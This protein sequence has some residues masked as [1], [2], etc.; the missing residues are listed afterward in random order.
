[1]WEFPTVATVPRTRNTTGRLREGNGM[2]TGEQRVSLAYR[3][4]EG[5][6]NLEREQGG[7]RD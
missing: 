6:E 2:A 1:M 5:K 7:G 3:I 4:A